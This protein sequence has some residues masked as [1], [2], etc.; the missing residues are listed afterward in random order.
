M[1]DSKK[2]KEELNLS[3]LSSEEKKEFIEFLKLLGK[4]KGII[5]KIRDIS[6][7]KLIKRLEDEIQIPVSIF[8]EKLSALES[9]CRYLKDELGYNNGKIS[10]L[11]NKRTK[12]IWQA[13]NNSRK[14]HPEKLIVESNK[15]DIPISILRERKSVLGSVVIFLKDQFN[16][17]YREI[18]FLL[19]RDERTIWTVYQRSKKK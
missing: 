14:K 12:S 9:I 5:D 8:N 19:H 10:G 2:T 18:S 6:D 17:T 13:Y 1:I 11:L 16:L 3:N 7:E 4:Y 15:F